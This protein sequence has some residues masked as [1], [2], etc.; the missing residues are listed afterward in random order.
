MQP[1]STA[2]NRRRP[3]GRRKTKCGIVHRA[4][5]RDDDM[6]DGR[7]TVTQTPDSQRQSPR[8]PI[9][10]C[11]LSIAGS[12]SGGGAGIQADVQTFAAHGILPCTAITA[13]TAQ[14]TSGVYNTLA[15][16]PALVTEQIDVVLDDLPVRALK[17]GMLA[18][19]ENVE[20]VAAVLALHPNI[21][22][23][24]DPVL[25]STSGSELLSENG[26]KLLR[27]R[28][29][30]L[31]T[32]VTPNLTE[33]A[34]LL[35]HP[36]DGMPASDIAQALFELTAGRAAIVLKGGD[37]EHSPRARDLALLPDGQEIWLDVPRVKTRSSHGTG[38][39]FAAAITANLARGAGLGDALRA[40]KHYVTGAL[41]NAIPVGQGHG[42]LNHMWQLK[43]N[44]P[45]GFELPP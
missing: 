17:T 3:D 25:A 33:A 20:A 32:V 42:P 19:E 15:V 14:N 28:L 38:C 6:S 21:P 11:A 30:P 27:Q 26:L 29:L 2:L 35:G 4:A 23:V 12:D 41:I 9:I 10:A 1:T 5:Q 24:V 16:P 36:I 43:R 13:I 44:D 37:V 34:K 7:Q 45:T 8:P 40:A 39:T 18:N 31:A 22:L